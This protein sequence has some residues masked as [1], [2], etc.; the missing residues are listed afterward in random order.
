VSDVY[1]RFWGVRGSVPTPGPE[2]RRYGGNTSCVEVRL[3]PHRLVF[4]AG[5]GIRPLGREW[6]RSRR[7]LTAH[8]FLSHLHFDHLCGLPFFAP[9]R[10]PAH[11]FRLWCGHLRAR[12]TTLA[13][14]LAQLVCQPFFPIP[15]EALAARLEYRDFRA[16]ETLEPEPGV[17]VRTA[18]LR[19]PGGATGYRVEYGGRILCYVTDTEHEEGVRDPAVT[20]LIRDADLVIY[21]CTYTDEEFPRFRGWGHST[22]QE[23]VRLVEAA[24]AGRLVV[25]HH[26][27][28]RDD[29]ALDAIAA[30][31]ERRRPGSRVA[32]EGLV[33]SL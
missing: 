30:E 25:F 16:G 1:V 13:A 28:D 18:P 14:T 9:L 31:L 4:D 22:W 6:L 12:G 7:P 11:R 3:G 2:T 19:H 32:R 10:D 23:G 8:L 5:T 27:P 26:H 17:V 15:L 24:G 20:A 29:D 33:L 21:D